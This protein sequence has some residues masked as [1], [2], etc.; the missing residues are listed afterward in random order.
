MRSPWIDQSESRDWIAARSIGYL[1]LDSN[2]IK[3][4]NGL[5]FITHVIAC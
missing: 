2:I 5:L 3:N 1:D 4:I